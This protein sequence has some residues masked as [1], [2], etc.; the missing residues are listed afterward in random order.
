MS[1]ST[2]P[3]TLVINL[4]TISI[5]ETIDH[6]Q[7]LVRILNKQVREKDNIP[8]GVYFY[9]IVQNKIKELEESGS[10]NRRVMYDL[11]ETIR[12]GR[13]V[14]DH[15]DICNL[16]GLDAVGNISESIETLIYRYGQIGDEEELILLIV[17]KVSQVYD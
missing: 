9:D 11:E 7:T 2:E 4:E 13:L 3:T 10:Y 16:T 17:Y 14:C 6:M 15:G 8:R 5:Q 12:T 1:E